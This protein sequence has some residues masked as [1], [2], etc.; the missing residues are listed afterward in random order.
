MC[1]SVFCLRFNPP[2]TALST[3][4]STNEWSFYSPHLPIALRS[5]GRAASNFWWT[6]WTT[7]WLTFTGVLVERCGTWCMAKPTMTTRSPWRTVAE[8]QRWSDCWGRPPMWRYE[9]FSQVNHTWLPHF[10]SHDGNWSTRWLLV[11]NAL[12][13]CLKRKNSLQCVN[14]NSG[15]CRRSG[16][17]NLSETASY[18]EV[19][20]NPEGF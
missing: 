6:C 15:A 12:I 14:S 13:C 1:V 19:R 5:G 18:C 7:G 10:V 2:T 16:V 9:N 3:E 4:R 8:Y 11:A 20:R 17:F